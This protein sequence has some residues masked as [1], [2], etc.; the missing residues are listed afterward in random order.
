MGSLWSDAGFGPDGDPDNGFRVL[1]GPFAS[2]RALIFNAQ[3]DDLEPR[4]TPGLIRRL[5]QGA[6][7]L[8]TEGQVNEL[9]TDDQYAQYDAAP[10]NT[11]VD[12]TRNRLEGFVNG[13]ALHNRVHVWVGGDMSPGT[14]PNDPIFWLHHANVDRIW[15]NWQLQ[16][17][18][19]NYQSPDG[20]NAPMPQLLSNVSPAAV[21]DIR[22][23]GYTYE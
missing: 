17:G 15:W 23:R 1:T 2:W 21:F 10:W 14:S 18:I 12:T 8:P 11:A 19:D 7:N 9:Y 16:R 4:D 3:T 5:G 20:P 6:S 22:L 13:P